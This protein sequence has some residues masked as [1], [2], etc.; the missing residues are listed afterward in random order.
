M[1]YSA[2]NTS[3]YVK[4]HVRTILY[5]PQ[6]S[7]IDTSIPGRKYGSCSF[8][9]YIYQNNGGWATIKVIL[10]CLTNY[11]GSSEGLNALLYGLGSTNNGFGLT[12][13]SYTRFNSD[14]RR[15]TGVPINTWTTSKTTPSVTSTYDGAMR[16][17]T[18][19]NT[20]ATDQTITLPPNSAVYL[21]VIATSES[22]HLVL[23]LSNIENPSK[24][25]IG[26]LYYYGNDSDSVPSRWLGYNSANSSTSNEVQVLN[27]RNTSSASYVKRV[28]FIF[29]NTSTASQ[30]VSFDADFTIT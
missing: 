24:L 27:F 7:L 15:Y 28:T 26:I 8:F 18:D 30:I 23:E 10:S 1:Q 25:P 16:L 14:P 20:T 5:Y 22:S 29:A 6:L 17:N 21:D 9:K 4:D 13:P 19:K 12:F 3:A 11:S 2:D